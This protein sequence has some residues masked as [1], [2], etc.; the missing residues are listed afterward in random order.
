MPNRQRAFAGPRFIGFLHSALGKQLGSGGL[1]ADD[2]V[3][4]TTVLCKTRDRQLDG[5]IARK[6]KGS[7]LVKKRQRQS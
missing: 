6:V 1:S 7:R 3:W 2:P 5:G 4:D